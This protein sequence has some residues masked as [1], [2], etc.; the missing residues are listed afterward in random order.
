MEANIFRVAEVKDFIQCLETKML[1]T[2]RPAS[3]II[4]DDVQVQEILHVSKRYMAS[5]R[6]QKLIEFSQPIENGKV[7]YTY[8][9]VLDFI[10]SGVRPTISQKRKF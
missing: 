4:L 10:A 1:Y 6:E 5:L 7:F 9:A 3:E 8:K 2:S